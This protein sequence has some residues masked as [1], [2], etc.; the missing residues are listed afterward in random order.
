MAVISLPADG[1]FTLEFFIFFLK[2]KNNATQT[3]NAIYLFILQIP[4]AGRA[5]N[6]T[7]GVG[8]ETGVALLLKNRL[9]H[10][11]HSLQEQAGASKAICN[12]KL[13]NNA[14]LEV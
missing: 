10:R 3:P 6:V 7:H 5:E 2:K 9:K 12:T 1:I 4:A 14:G 8:A 13:T 11:K